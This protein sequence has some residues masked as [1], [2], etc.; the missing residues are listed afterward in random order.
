MRK[1]FS[2]E[3]TDPLHPAG[4]EIKIPNRDLNRRSLEGKDLYSPPPSSHKR[5]SQVLALSSKNLLD[6][7]GSSNFSFSPKARPEQIE[8][9]AGLFKERLGPDYPPC[10]S[11]VL[12]QIS[13]NQY[14][15]ISPEC[16]ELAIALEQS[17]LLAPLILAVEKL[18]TPD[19]ALY[20]V[21]PLY[22]VRAKRLIEAALKILRLP[23]ISS[24]LIRI[25][26]DEAAKSIISRGAEDCKNQKLL[27]L[28]DETKDIVN[29]Y[30]ER[31]SILLSD[32]AEKGIAIL[33]DF[34]K[35]SED[36]QIISDLSSLFSMDPYPSEKTFLF[37][38]YKLL[39]EKKDAFR[40]THLQKEVLLQ[41]FVQ[42]ILH[43]N[44]APLASILNIKKMSQE[45]LIVDGTDSLRTQRLKRSTKALIS[46]TVLSLKELQFMLFWIQSNLAKTSD[47]LDLA[48][49]TRE[50][51]PEGKL[52]QTAVSR[53]LEL[54][55]RMKPDL[56]LL[57]R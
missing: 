40:L 28:A 15:F 54:A 33:F 16:C 53:F 19:S 14:V 24:L 46:T 5:I 36:Q 23:Q 29:H 55:Q 49:G 35:I 45:L 37:A 51:D 52:Y 10:L 18:S 20:R 56:E 22:K 8:E 1:Q 39:C 27:S 13:Y 25:D 2:A 50:W 44:L 11:Q 4:L 9:L 26:V 47:T 42:M 7:A 21:I 17:N 43:P 3:K 31:R 12:A 34:Y 38:T 6:A 41:Q 30:R 57:A 48:G 32:I